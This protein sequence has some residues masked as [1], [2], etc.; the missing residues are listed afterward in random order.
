MRAENYKERLA[1]VVGVEVY[2]A[3]YQ[4]GDLFHCVV[5]NESTLGNLVRSEGKSRDEAER[6]ALDNATR[7]LTVGR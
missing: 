6:R 2:L 4:I 3:S 7:L 1:K 5:K